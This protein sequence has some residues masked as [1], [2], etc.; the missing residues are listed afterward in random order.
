M[1]CFV[2]TRMEWPRGVGGVQDSIVSRDLLLNS[3]GLLVSEWFRRR[4][5]KALSRKRSPDQLCRYPGIYYA[6]KP[7]LLCDLGSSSERGRY[8]AHRAR[9]TELQTRNT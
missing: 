4:T 5:E 6:R 2:K 7:F 1:F 8:D 9:H 3:T